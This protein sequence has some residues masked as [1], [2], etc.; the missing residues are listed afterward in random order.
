MLTTMHHFTDTRL[1]RVVR[2][3][4][5]RA[6]SEPAEAAQVADH[7][8]DANLRGHDSHG[9]GMIPHYVHNIT[10][11]TMRPNTGLSVVRDGGAVMG[12]DGGMGFGQRVGAEMMEHLIPRARELGAVVAS[13]R[14][15]HHL[16]RIG[17]YAEMA[18]AAGLVSIHFVNVIGHPPLVAPHRGSQAR[19]GTN[20]IAIGVPGTSRHA[21]FLLDMATSRIALGK[22]RV[23][24]NKGERVEPGILVDADGQPTTDPK[25]MFPDD[26]ALRGA[27]LPLGLHKGYGLLFAAELLAGVVG[28]GETSHPGTAGRDTICNGMLSVVIDPASLTDPEGM[29]RE[30]DI[31]VDYVTSSPPA[32]PDEPVLVAG[33][34]ER[35]T[36]EKRLAEGIPVDPVTWE[37]IL[38]AGER[39]GLPR[40]EAQALVSGA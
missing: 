25:V 34:P 33:A 24:L 35:M 11:K 32:N 16:G 19:F 27:L 3:L 21:P 36:M 2:T 39:V 37:G 38:D 12:F 20:P 40:S 5:E 22:V 23:A 10:G 31:I 13:L 9:V 8:V 14:N 18:V 4:L 17:A 15:V 7:L 6:G 29:E 28:G 30:L 26:E 1:R